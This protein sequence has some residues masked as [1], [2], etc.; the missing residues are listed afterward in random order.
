MLEILFVYLAWDY[1][2]G[3]WRAFAEWLWSWF[4]AYIQ[5]IFDPARVLAAALKVFNY[6]L[7]TVQAALPGGWSSHIDAFQNEI[8]SPWVAAL[9]RI[10]M[11]VIDHV[12]QYQVA[13]AGLLLIVSFWPVFI[14]I[15]IGLK[16]YHQAW[17]SD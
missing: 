12:V 15:R 1:L 13:W 4:V 10:V 5:F 16:I 8:G 9:G 17:G 7:D 14:I 2:T 6:L 3:M 11:Y